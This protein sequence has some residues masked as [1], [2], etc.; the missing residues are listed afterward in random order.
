MGN[1]PG[2]HKQRLH[3]R[4]IPRG[5]SENAERHF[6]HRAWQCG[7]IAG[8]FWRCRSKVTAPQPGKITDSATVGTAIHQGGI[9]AK[10]ESG[11]QTTEV[12]S[13]ISGRLR[14][15]SVKAGQTIAA[16]DEIAMLDPGTDQVWEALRALYLIGRPE[17]IPAIQPYQRELPEVPDHVR[18]QAMATEQAIRERSK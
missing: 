1:G 9:I 2:C 5:A 7:A 15:F 17:D 12:R 8:A 11:G 14:E 10:L 18:K 4:R 6:P 3:Q 13:P 16:G